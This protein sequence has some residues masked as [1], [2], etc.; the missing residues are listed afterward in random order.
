MA[1]IHVVFLH[2]R[3]TEV[4]FTQLWASM[5]VYEFFET[6]DGMHYL[7]TPRAGEYLWIRSAQFTLPNIGQTGGLWEE[8]RESRCF[9]ARLVDP[10]GGAG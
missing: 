1:P 5:P 8:A 3:L 6:G 2:S 10:V 4:R 7:T 9:W